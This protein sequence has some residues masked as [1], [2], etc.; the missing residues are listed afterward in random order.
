MRLCPFT[1]NRPHLAR[2]LTLHQGTSMMNTCK[3]RSSRI[4]NVASSAQ[5]F[6]DISFEDPNW[7]AR[8]YQA[9]GAYGQS[10][11]ANVFFTLELAKRLP[12]SAQVTA[13]CLHPGVVATEL[14]R[15][16]ASTDGCLLS[17]RDC[18]H[19]LNQVLPKETGQD[20][21]SLWRSGPGAWIH[22]RFRLHG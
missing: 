8:K 4:V 11:L 6:G 5:L 12:A 2:A 15:C 3:C 1:C 22:C 17:G 18:D 13:N 20:A 7:E 21:C 9:W 19:D 14:A 10:K 16:C